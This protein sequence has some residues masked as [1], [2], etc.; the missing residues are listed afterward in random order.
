MNLFGNLLQNWLRF[1]Q[2]IDKTMQ[3]YPQPGPFEGGNPVPNIYSTAIID[4]I[5]HCEGD[6]MKVRTGHFGGAFLS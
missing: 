4:R 2:T 6:N 1:K 5:R 3:V